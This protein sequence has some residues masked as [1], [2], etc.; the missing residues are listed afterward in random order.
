VRIALRTGIGMLMPN[1]VPMPLVRKL[2][3]SCAS[4]CHELSPAPPCRTSRA[5]M[6]TLASRPQHQHAATMQT[7]AFSGRRGVARAYSLALVALQKL[8]E[9]HAHALQPQPLRAAP[10]YS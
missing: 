9:A 6:Q 5:N 2:A 7:L 4:T 8:V 3:R 1:L 10:A